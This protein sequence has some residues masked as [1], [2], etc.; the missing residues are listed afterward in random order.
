MRFKRL[1]LTCTVWHRS[2]T[3]MRAT[4]RWMLATMVT[5]ASGPLAASA[6]DAIGSPHGDLFHK[7]GWITPAIYRKAARANGSKPATKSTSAGAAR[8]TKSARVKLTRNPRSNS[9]Q[10]KRKKPQ[11][12]QRTASKSSSKLRAAAKARHLK[13]KKPWVT[14]GHRIPKRIAKHLERS[15]KPPVDLQKYA[16][17]MASLD[18]DILAVP[19]ALSKNS[20]SRAGVT[21]GSPRINWIASSTC[22]PG[23]LRAAIV[24]VARNYWQNGALLAPRGRRLQALWRRSVSHRHRTTPAL[25]STIRQ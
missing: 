25:V 15:L 14:N 24:Y 16:V 4:G 20:D 13:R 3:V 19:P 5:L 6:D 23:R 9:G 22:L 2:K 8:Y 18:V 17:K 1:A 11:R 21:G 7:K 10:R 12:S